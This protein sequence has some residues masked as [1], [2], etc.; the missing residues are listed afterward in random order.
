MTECDTDHCD[1]TG[2]SRIEIGKGNAT[3]IENVTE[4]VMVRQ[5]NRSDAD[6]PIENRQ[7]VL[8]RDLCLAR[9]REKTLRMT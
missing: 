1:E 6:G 7:S 9:L 3:V 5:E 4:A 2:E 8:G